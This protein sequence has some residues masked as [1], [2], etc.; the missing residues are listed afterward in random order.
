[1]KD[2]KDYEDLYAITEDGKVW[3]KPRH[4]GYR[5]IGGYWMKP[6]VY[7]E[8]YERVLLCK[9]GKATRKSIHRLVAEA[10]L[11]RIEGLDVVN[12]KDEDKLNNHFSN[13]E[14]C[15]TQ[16]NVEYSAAKRRKLDL[17]FK[18]WYEFEH[19][20]HGIKRVNRVQ[21]LAEE[22]GISKGQLS[23]L[24]NGRLKSAKGWVLKD[25][26]KNYICPVTFY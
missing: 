15:T 18:K 14:W 25:L 4:T 11:D 22:F 2:I 5:H 1:M 26:Y 19:P 8:G 6:Q 12:H 24:V 16:Y 10:Y 9:E 7:S 23:G 21:R 17:S 13:L 3:S 20:D